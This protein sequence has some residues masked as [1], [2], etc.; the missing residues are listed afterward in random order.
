MKAIY[1]L[2][3]L[4]LWLLVVI[5]RNETPQHQLSVAA[6]S[7]GPNNPKIPVVA[8]P[9]DQDNQS[10]FKLKDPL[11]FIRESRAER[12]AFMKKEAEMWT[13]ELKQLSIKAIVKRLEAVMTPMMNSFQVDSAT[14][15]KVLEIIHQLETESMDIYSGSLNDGMNGMSK[16]KNSQEAEVELARHR[17]E[18][19]IGA[20]HAGA[21]LMARKDVLNRMSAEGIKN[22]KLRKRD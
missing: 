19:L 18:A 16:Q 9:L 20:E 6:E 17:L 3:P 14:S 1:L 21:L 12:D 5:Y 22:A 13:D 15:K 8:V 10:R 2:T 7:A 4:A 11:E